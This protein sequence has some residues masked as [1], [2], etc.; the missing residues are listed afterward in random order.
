MHIRFDP[1]AVKLE[2]YFNQSGSGGASRYFE[3][4][5][6]YQRGYGFYTAGFPR[7]RG[8][9]FGDVFRRFLRFLNL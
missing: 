9:G 7:Q 8:Y 2:S 4:L 1:A 5:P 6:P 3:G